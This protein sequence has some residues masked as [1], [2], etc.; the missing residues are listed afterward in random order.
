MKNL[1]ILI[2]AAIAIFFLWTKVLKPWLDKP[3]DITGTSAATSGAAAAGGSSCPELAAKASEVWGS[4]IGAFA[5][6]PV[7]IASWDAFHSR[8]DSAIGAADSS[9]TCSSDSCVKAR[10]AVG[11]LRTLVS[12]FDTALRAGSSPPSDAVQQQEHIDQLID[13]ARELVR[14]G[15]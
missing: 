4:G 2:I 7:D 15:K 14:Q 5:N 9:C 3:A 13:Q 11:N 8:V 1:I 6:P 10:E 12:G